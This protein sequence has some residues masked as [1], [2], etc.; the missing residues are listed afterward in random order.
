MSTTH[1]TDVIAA[2]RETVEKML[3]QRTGKRAWVA[4]VTTYGGKTASANRAGQTVTLNLPSLPPDTMLSRA[5]ADRMIAYIAHEVCHMLHTDFAWWNSV[6]AEGS[7]IKSWTNAL[8]DVRIEA[9]ELKEGPYKALRGLLSPLVE[10]LYA[11]ARTALAKTGGLGKSEL[12]APYI[13]TVLGRAANG[14]ELPTTYTLKGELSPNVQTV[15]QG[16]LDGVKTCRSTYDCHMLA[17]ELVALEQALKASQEKDA[18]DQD[19]GDQDA[20]DQDAGD[21]GGKDQDASDQGA[22]GDKG[23]NQKPKDQKPEQPEI[24]PDLNLGKTCEN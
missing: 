13:T 18:D 11:E 21:Q 7:R 5:E 3:V 2:A 24:N 19:Q 17:R 23:G 4:N 16:A 14:Y 20:G 9:K 22:K 1:Y 6:V 15:V 12:N 10:H 8:E